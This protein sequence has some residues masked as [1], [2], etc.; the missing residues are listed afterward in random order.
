MNID[1]RSEYPIEIVG[2]TLDQMWEE[3]QD[4]YVCAILVQ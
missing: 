2:I 4:R 1:S 3:Q